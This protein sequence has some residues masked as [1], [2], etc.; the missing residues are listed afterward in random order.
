MFKLG[1]VVTSVGQTY[2]IR[3]SGGRACAKARAEQNQSGFP[4][5]NQMKAKKKGYHLNL[6]R[7]FAQNWVQAK[8]KGLRLPFAYP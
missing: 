7:F 6:I 4:V 3:G 2:R 1:D 8:N 5:Q